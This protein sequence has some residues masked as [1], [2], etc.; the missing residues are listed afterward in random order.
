VGGG[1][2]RKIVSSGVWEGEEPA[3]YK[4]PIKQAAEII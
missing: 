2:P 4:Y 1:H 3:M